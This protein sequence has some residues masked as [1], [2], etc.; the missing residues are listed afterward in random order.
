[1]YRLFLF[2]FAASILVA[3]SAAGQSFATDR[4]SWLVGGSASFTSQGGDMYEDNGDR[5][6]TISLSPSAA[7]FVTR[8]LA[9]GGAVVFDR[10]SQGDF[11]AT[12]LGVGPSF[13]YFFG[14]PN[15]SV[16]PFI[17]V[18]PVYTTTSVDLGDLGNETIDGYGVIAQG[19]VALLLTRNVAFTV[20]AFY[21][22]EKQ[23]H[24]D[25]DESLDGNS[26]GL[27]V[28]LAAFVF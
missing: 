1:M 7:Y 4:G 6:N 3:P 10:L 15:A 28:G 2:I 14:S 22:Y 11:S 21:A 13:F 26:F 16:Y 17:G 25:L 20:G 27:R 5:L 12:S 24:E 9:V 8:G 23:N 19:G 18:N